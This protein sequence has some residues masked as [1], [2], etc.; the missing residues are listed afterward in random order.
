MLLWHSFCYKAFWL[1]SRSDHSWFRDI[2]LRAQVKLCSRIWEMLLYFP[3]CSL[4]VS[5][6]CFQMQ[7]LRETIGLNG[8]SHPNRWAFLVKARLEFYDWNLVDNFSQCWLKSWLRIGEP[9]RESL[10]LFRLRWSFPINRVEFVQEF[11]SSI[12]ET[13]VILYQR[14]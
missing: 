10:T 8:S 1:S 14:S 7:F 3:Y 4:F 5:N 6:L 13:S 9:S 2:K 12:H 11:C